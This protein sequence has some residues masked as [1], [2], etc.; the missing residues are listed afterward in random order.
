MAERESGK[1]ATPN[2][3]LARQNIDILEML[4]EKTR[5][6]L[7]PEETRLLESLLFDLRMRFVETKRSPAP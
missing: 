5:G 7:D 6:N 2:W 3:E 1:P 4:Q